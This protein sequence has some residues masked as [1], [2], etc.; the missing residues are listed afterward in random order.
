MKKLLSAALAAAML[1]S[2]AACGATADTS[3]PA[4]D[5]GD[6][7]AADDAAAPA[8][9][10]DAD[11][12]AEPAE[13]YKVA[14]LQFMRH[15]SLDEIS[16]AVEAELDAKSEE[17]GVKFEYTFMDGNQDGPTIQ[18]LAKQTLDD[19][20][21]LIIPIATPAAQAAQGVID[22]AIP[23]V[24]SAVSDPESA[25]LTGEEN[26]TGTSDALDPTQLLEM[27][28]A[29][30][31]DLAK[32]GLLYSPSED[33]SKVPVAEATA[34]L[35]EKGI[36][37]QEYPASSSSDVLTAVDALIADGVDAVLTPTDNTIMGQAAAVGERLLDAGILYYAGADVF[38]KAGGFAASS[39]DYT[40]LGT[41]TADMAVDILMGGEVPEY[42]TVPGGSIFIN[43]DVAQALELD[44]SAL[45]A[46]VDTYTEVHTGDE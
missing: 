27:M 38:A 28:Q 18:D 19:G 3:A 11:T 25:L 26:V 20:Y 13:T 40:E 29:M 1:L 37:V 41:A 10:A 9:D 43:T 7:T 22:G 35:K 30:D 17:L 5:T 4:D 23:L 32:V 46:V 14:I 31:P 44:L 34:Y 2:L 6:T 8:G 12:A 45:D 24:Y 21:D 33:A 36:D 16:D 39:V 15:A 42:K